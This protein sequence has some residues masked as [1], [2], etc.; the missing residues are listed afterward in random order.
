VGAASVAVTNGDNKLSVG[1]I[2]VSR[3][4]PALFTANASGQ[5][6]PS[7]SILRVRNGAQTFEAVSEAPIDLGPE[8]DVVYLLLYGTGVR[9]SAKAEDYSVDF[10]GVV[11]TLSAA[12]FEGGFAVP[13]FIGLDQINVV[14]PRNLVGKGNVKLTL[15]VEGKP[16]NPVQLNIK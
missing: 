15:T 16:A 9:N 8:S 14:L 7:A 3:L 1:T 12:N 6:I 13:G 10:G 11:K 2:N 4:A 5:G